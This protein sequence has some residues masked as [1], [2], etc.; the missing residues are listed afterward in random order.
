M[1]AEDWEDYYAAI[2]G[3]SVRPLL[4][5][6]IARIPP[7]EPGYRP[8]QAV[9]LGCGDGT[10][11]R[12]LLARGWTVLAIDRSPQAIARV[13]ASVPADDRT[14]QLQ[15]RSPTSSCRRPT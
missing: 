5:E 14:R 9:D 7:P 8:L 13:H 2:E 6:A 12:E 3:R 11:T 4:L 10:E 15:A 1:A